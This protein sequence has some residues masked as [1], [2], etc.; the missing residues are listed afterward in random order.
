MDE[1]SPVIPKHYSEECPYK[2]DLEVL[3]TRT[4]NQTSLKLPNLIIGCRSLS[5]I[6]STTVQH[7]GALT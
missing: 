5:M 4:E 7:S 2:N 6:V 1:T 3:V